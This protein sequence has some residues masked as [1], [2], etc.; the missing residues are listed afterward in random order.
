M[1][2]FPFWRQGAKWTG[3]WGLRATKDVAPVL[4][5]GGRTLSLRLV[6]VP[7]TSC[8]PRIHHHVHVP[9]YCVH[10]FFWGLPSSCLGLAGLLEC[11]SRSR[12]KAHL[13]G[14]GTDHLGGRWSH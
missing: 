8:S 6:Q 11:G 13:P 4:D 14:G 3:A 9:L 1:K 7:H 12:L 5:L 10:Y 2:G